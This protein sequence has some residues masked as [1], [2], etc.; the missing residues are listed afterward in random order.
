ML[1]ALFS[2][3]EVEELSFLIK[4]EMETLKESLDDPNLHGV[5]YRAINERYKMLFGLLKRFSSE[6]EYIKYL[7]K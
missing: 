5:V 6:R 3:L 4:K 2:D 1:G 7:R